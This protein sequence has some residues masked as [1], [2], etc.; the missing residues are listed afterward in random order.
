MDPEKLTIFKSKLKIWEFAKI[1]SPE[2][3]NLPSDDKSSIL[4][5]YHV[6]VLSKY[7]EFSKNIQNILKLFFACFLANFGQISGDY[8][9]KS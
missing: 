3:Q 1:S 6:D 7:P 2:F 9:A 4:K 5:K 8:W